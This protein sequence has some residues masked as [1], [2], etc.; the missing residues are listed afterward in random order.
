MKGIIFTLGLLLIACAQVKYNIFL[1][2]MK[3]II[4]LNKVFNNIRVGS[5]NK[6]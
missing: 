3:A 4:E 1:F 2:Y 5:C 6:K